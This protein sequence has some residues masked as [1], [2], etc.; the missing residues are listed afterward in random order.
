MALPASGPIS[1][2]QIGTELG[3]VAPYS[4]RSMSAAA[5]F[6]TPDAMSEFYSFSDLNFLLNLDA[7][8]TNSYGGSGTTWTDISGKGNNGTLT[9]KNSSNPS[10]NSD[11]GFQFAGSSVGGGTYQDGKYV[12]TVDG[13]FAR[14]QSQNKVTLSVWFYPTENSY[15]MIIAG[16]GF[17]STLSQGYTIFLAGGSVY[18]RISI[19][20]SSTFTDI[21]TA[22]TF[23]NWNHCF[24]TYDGSNAKFYKNNSLIATNALSGT[25]SGIAPNRFLIGGQY[26]A[27][28]GTNT[29]EFYTGYVSKVRLYSR[30]LDDNERTAIYNAGY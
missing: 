24:L 23:D 16:I 17:N 18:G 22:A 5:G 19:N 1:G 25:I 12:S 20:D 14:V 8:N 27:T 26:N 7:L 2:S 11:L 15:P 3:D 9:N 13:A 6:S 28:G 21:S 4:L 29:A 10:W 30:V